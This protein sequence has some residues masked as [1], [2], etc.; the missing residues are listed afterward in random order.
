MKKS[1]FSKL[2]NKFIEFIEN[3]VNEIYNLLE[4]N[5]YKRKKINYY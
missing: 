2:L 4:I 5:T 1:I 3:N